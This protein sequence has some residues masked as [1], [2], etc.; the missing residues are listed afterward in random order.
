[1]P[2]IRTTKPEFFTSEQVMNLSIFARFAF[3]GMWNFC[4]D[5]GNHPASPKTLKAE[6]FPSDDVTSTDVQGYVD[7]MLDQGL[8]AVYEAAG[9]QFWHVTGWHHQR[10][11]KPTIKHPPFSENSTPPRRRVEEPAKN[12]PRVLDEK[13]ESATGG[14]TPGVEGIG[15]ESKVLERTGDDVFRLRADAPPPVPAKAPAPAKRKPAEQETPK[16][17]AT[18]EAYDAAYLERYG[19]PHLRN[20]KVNGQMLN[21]MRLLPADVAP[22]VAAFYVRHNNAFYVAKG[23]SVGMLLADAEKLHME[24]AS[25][26]QITSAQ[27]RQMDRTQTNYNAFA[28]MLE[29]ARARE[30][31]QRSGTFTDRDYDE[32]LDAAAAK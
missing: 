28:P 25:G 19:V 13:S 21:L 20:P 23:H 2:R 1:M 15:V 24:W 12:P 4:D 17:T 30:A 5:G 32:D 11:D 6:V 31:A 8:L 10:I 18:W 14:L 26:K 27:A 9:K 16:T 3:L 22:A 29:A 7:E